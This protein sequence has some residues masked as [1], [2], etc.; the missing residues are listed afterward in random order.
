[1]AVLELNWSMMSGYVVAVVAGTV[2]V[3]CCAAN[4]AGTTY[5]DGVLPQK[6]FMDPKVTTFVNEPKRMVE[7]LVRSMPG[8]SENE[9]LQSFS[10]PSNT[11][12]NCW[13]V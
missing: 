8:Y 5:S 13:V 6:K 2:E 1:M 4:V 10:V 12:P 9:M 7:T 3:G 11:R